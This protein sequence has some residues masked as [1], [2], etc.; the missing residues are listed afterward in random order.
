MISSRGFDSQASSAA[1]LRFGAKS[2]SHPVRLNARNRG[3]M[4]SLSV[5]AGL[6]GLLRGSALLIGMVIGWF[7]AMPR[8]ELNSVSW[9][10]DS[11]CF[12]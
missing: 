1:L 12:F 10:Q 4:I 8:K 5:Q 9:S 2:I 7:V 6:W 11:R 3:V